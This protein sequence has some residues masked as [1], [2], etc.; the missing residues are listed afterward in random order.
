MLPNSQGHPSPRLACL[1]KVPA[2]RNGWRNLP[3][4]ETS[5]AA[6]VRRETRSLP[7]PPPSRFRIP[8]VS[9]AG[10]R[11]GVGARAVWRGED[12]SPRARVVFPGFSK[13][14]KVCL[15]GP[16]I[17]SSRK[18]DPKATWSSFTLPG[19]GLHPSPGHSEFLHS[20]T[21]LVLDSHQTS[22]PPSPCQVLRASPPPRRELPQEEVRAHEP[23][24]HQEEVEVNSLEREKTR[25]LY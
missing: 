6:T 7:L 9:K 24:A 11:F 22:S 19:G 1:Q 4:S 14:H 17:L 3:G 12:A 23:V 21:L 25:F 2:A 16:S 20:P 18:T 13:G 5:R 15:D 10:T 8:P